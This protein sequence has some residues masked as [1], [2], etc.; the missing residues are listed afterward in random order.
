MRT[1]VTPLK[2]VYDVSFKRR[3]SGRL[4]NVRVQAPSI[5]LASA[6]AA[7]VVRSR[8]PNK[9]WHEYGISQATVVE[10]LFVTYSSK[11]RE[12]RWVPLSLERGQWWSHPY[13]QYGLSLRA[14]V[15]K[16]GACPSP[17]STT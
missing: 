7:A 12:S 8:Y 14:S 3:G 2:D 17:Q 16:E 13:G 4:L 6:L 1:R 11:G 9:G 15:D 10:G 5:C